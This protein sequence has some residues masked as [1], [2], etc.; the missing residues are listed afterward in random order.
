[1]P[2]NPEDIELDDAGEEDEDAGA[3]DAGGVQLEQKAVPVRAYP[4]FQ[5]CDLHARPVLDLL[6]R[7]T[8]LMC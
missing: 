3:V 6:R 1:M 5:F 4:L 7:N 8:L 2:A